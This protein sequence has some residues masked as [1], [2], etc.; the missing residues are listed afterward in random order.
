MSQVGKELIESLPFLLGMMAMSLLMGLLI[1]K[2]KLPKWSFIAFFLVAIGISLFMNGLICERQL[3]QEFN[4]TVA[5]T[6]KRYNGRMETY[7]KNG[8]LPLSHLTIYKTDSIMVG[9]SITKRSGTC[10]YLY[11]KNSL[12]NHHFHKKI[13]NL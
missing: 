7:D 2:K 4:F 13:C 11:R 5:K 12:G 10:L 1:Y 8:K 3:K 9:D 6:V